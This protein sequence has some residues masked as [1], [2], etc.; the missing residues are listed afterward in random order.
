[1]ATPLEMLMEREK[2]VDYCDE[3]E[4]YIPWRRVACCEISGKLLHPIWVMR[5]D[6]HGPA[7]WCKNAVRRA[8]DG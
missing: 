2:H 8:N 4:H 5:C 7:Y 1:M 6:G 3:C